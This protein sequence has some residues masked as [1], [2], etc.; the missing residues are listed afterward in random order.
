VSAVVADERW[1]TASVIPSTCTDSELYRG[2]GFSR[3]RFYV[4]KK[5]GAFDF[6]KAQPQI[7]GAATQYS[8]HRISKWLRGE[9][10]V[11]GQARQFFVASARRAAK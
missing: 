6:L 3:S 11:P 8:G 1:T 4:L 2:L 10:V 5:R 9:L 7:A